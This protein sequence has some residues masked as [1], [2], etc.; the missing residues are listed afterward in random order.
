MS[1]TPEIM[2][3]YLCLPTAY[4]IWSVLAKTFYD[5]SDELQVIALN[6]RAFSAK[7]S[8]KLLSVYYGELK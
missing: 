2:K 8:G 1:T 3:R 4:E 7:Q 5:G 6:K